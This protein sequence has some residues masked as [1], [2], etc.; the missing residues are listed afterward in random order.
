MPSANT[1]NIAGQTDPLRNLISLEAANQLLDD[2][3]IR[4]GRFDKYVAKIE[5]QGSGP[6]DIFRTK[7]QIQED[8]KQERAKYSRGAGSVDLD[9]GDLDNTFQGNI[10]DSRPFDHSN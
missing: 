9:W 3:V 7:R 4:R 8:L 10:N 1:T 2:L 5:K 6:L